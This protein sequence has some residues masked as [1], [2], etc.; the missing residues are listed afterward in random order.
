MKIIDCRL[1]P[2]IGKYA[3]NFLF[4]MIEKG[5]LKKTADQHGCSLPQS[6][7][8]RSME[9]LIKEMDAQGVECGYFAIRQSQECGNEI[10]EE[11]AEKY[12]GRFKSFIGIDPYGD[13]EKYT[14]D[15]EY[16]VKK[17][18]AAGI[19][20]EPAIYGKP[21]YADDK[22]VYPIYQYCRDNQ[23]PVML[24]Y[25][26]RTPA[27]ATYYLPAPI[28]HVAQDFPELRMLLLHGGWPWVVPNCSLALNYKNVYLCPD[29]YLVRAPGHRDYIDAANYFLSDKLMFGSAYPIL[30]IEDAVE[31]YLS[32]GIKEEVLPNIMYNNALQAITF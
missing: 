6:G 5:Y 27:D 8:K 18:I 19:A 32:C 13:K 11:L 30:S 14:E 17:G 26:G 29:M 12:P 21:W 23:I 16:Y 1:R 15:I 22:M 2:P 20:M 24:T 3:D 10:A 7:K 4:E 31:F 25:G 9:L 28:E